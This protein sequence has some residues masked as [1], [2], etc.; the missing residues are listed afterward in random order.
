M[1]LFCYCICTGAADWEGSGK[2]HG[3]KKRE[4]RAV[5]LIKPCCGWKFAWLCLSLSSL[6]FSFDSPI[7]FVGRA[8]FLFSC[9]KTS[10]RNGRWHLPISTALPPR[11]VGHSVQNSDPRC[12][13][14]RVSICLR[15]ARLDLLGLFLYGQRWVGNDVTDPAMCLVSCVFFCRT[16]LCAVLCCAVLCVAS[17]IVRSSNVSIPYSVDGSGGL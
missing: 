9:C 13:V 2:R 10:L 6:F 14:G 15:C 3:E 5:F 1:V 17:A 11:T 4:R 7:V 12:P 16:V 8:F